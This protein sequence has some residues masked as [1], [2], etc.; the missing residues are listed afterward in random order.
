MPTI[1][2]NEENEMKN[3]EEDVQYS[4]V[5]SDEELEA[6]LEEFLE[7]A[8]TDLNSSVVQEILLRHTHEERERQNPTES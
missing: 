8:H 1:M 3:D 2:I 5:P 6:R 4:D 7:G